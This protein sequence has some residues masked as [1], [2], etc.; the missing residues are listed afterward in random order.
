MV[1][2]GPWWGGR[3]RAPGEAR[4]DVEVGVEEAAAYAVAESWWK[5]GWDHL[6]RSTAAQRT[7]VGVEAGAVVVGS[8]VLARGGVGAEA[9][10]SEE[11]SLLE[12]R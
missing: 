11:E 5:V 9:P 4:A 1:R 10:W 6:A 12:R 2:D 8:R 7:G 3:L